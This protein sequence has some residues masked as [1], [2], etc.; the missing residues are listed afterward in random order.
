MKTNRNEGITNLLKKPLHTLKLK[1]NSTEPISQN[2]NKV[3]HLISDLSDDECKELIEFVKLLKTD[4]QA[5]DEKLNKLREEV[6]RN[7]KG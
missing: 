1:L 6:L 7:G 5:A 2:P 4:P 3:S